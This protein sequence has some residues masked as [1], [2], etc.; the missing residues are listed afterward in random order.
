VVEAPSDEITLQDLVDTIRGLQESE[1]HALDDKKLLN[2]VGKADLGGGSSV[3]ITATLQNAQLAF[4]Q[5][6]VMISSGTTT[7]G[8]ATNGLPGVIFTDTLADFVTDDIQPGDVAI[9]LTD[10]STATVIERISDTQI[11]TYTLQD[12]GDNTWQN[13]DSYGIWHVIECE[14]KS[15]NLVAV[16]SAGDP[17][18]A[19]LSM[20]FVSASKASASSGTLVETGTS[21]LT[22]EE[23]DALLQIAA[24]QTTIQGDIAL[25]QPDLEYIKAIEEG[26]WEIVGNQMIFYDRTSPTPVEIA[27]FN[28]F[29]SEGSPTSENIYKRVPI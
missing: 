29:D 27:R 7:S 21:G 23:S 5:R 4:E 13:G 1:L 10:G 12:G 11:K 22:Q 8:Q 3:E 18:P 14:V 19:I 9:N 6:P 26:T 25:I 15:G 16:D 24:D 2:A 28:L 17:I 20:A